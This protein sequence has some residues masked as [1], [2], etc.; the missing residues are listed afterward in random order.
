MGL[1]IS[2]IPEPIPETD[3]VLLQ[4]DANTAHQ[5][6][7]YCPTTRAIDP[8]TYVDAYY[9]VNGTS[10][11]SNP[12]RL[13]HSFPADSDNE[14]PEYFAGSAFNL[15][16]GTLYDTKIEVNEP[17]TTMAVLTGTY[18]TTSLPANAGLPT[19][20]ATPS[21][22]ATI[23]ANPLPAGTVLYLP[24]GTYDLSSGSYGAVVTS[25]GTANNKVYI[26]GES[27]AGTIIQRTTGNYLLNIKGNHIIFDNITFQG[28]G[29]NTGVSSDSKALIVSDTTVFNNH[30]IRFCKFIGFDCG[31]RA[32]TQVNNVLMYENILI[33]NNTHADLTGV[34]IAGWTE[35][36]GWSDSAITIPG[37][38]NEVF[39]NNLS[40]FGDSYKVTDEA[41]TVGMSKASY[42]HH[43][44]IAFS[45]DDGVGEIDDGGRNIYL[46]DNN[47]ANSATLFS[48]DLTHGGPNGAIRNIGINIARH[49]YKLTDRSQGTQIINNTI[50]E[51]TKQTGR[52]FG[53]LLSSSGNPIDLIMRNN[54]LVYTG[55]GGMMQIDAPCPRALGG[56]NGWSRDGSF[57]FGSTGGGTF[58]NLAAAKAGRPDLYLND[59]IVGAAPFNVAVTL[60]ADYK[61]QYTGTRSI[62]LSA[63]SL[64]KNSGIAIG[65]V[66]DGF[67]GVA[68][69]LGAIISGQN[70]GVVGTT[71]AVISGVAEEPSALPTWVPATSTT[72][73]NVN[74]LTKAN[75]GLVNDFIETTAPNYEPFYHATIVNAYSGGVLNK[76]YGEY[77]SFFLTGAGHA[78]GNDN[79]LTAM[80]L[81]EN[82]IS[83]RRVID[84]SPYFDSE[85][86]L[87]PTQIKGLNAFGD[88]NY[89]ISGPGS[90]PDAMGVSRVD[91]ATASAIVDGKPVAIHSYGIPVIIP[92]SEGGSSKGTLYLPMLVAGNRDLAL[93]TGSATSYLTNLT[94][95]T[96]PSNVQAWVR[97]FSHPTYPDGSSQILYNSINPP[98]HCVY[99]PVFSRIMY[100]SADIFQ[101]RWINPS[102]T[103][104]ST[105]WVQGTGTA[106]SRTDMSA[107]AARVL[108]IPERDLFIILYRKLSDSTL[109]IKYMQNAAQ[110]SWNNTNV[111]L[112]SSTL[113]DTDWSAATWCPDIP[114]G[115]RICVFDIK[116]NRNA[117]VEITIPNTLTDTW[118]VEQVGLSQT[119]TNFKTSAQRQADN[120]TVYGRLEYNSKTK[121]IVYYGM[122]GQSL[123]DPDEVF[124]IRPRGV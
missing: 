73:G 61:T 1:Q 111:T 78:A 28:N 30:T 59:K 82:N 50:V 48:A 40:G 103:T 42:F 41:H 49:P 67:T 60:G 11:W 45:S 88:F 25:Q 107:V 10:T 85:T 75:G 34:G 33:G 69:D 110:P 4:Y 36:W 2:F 32:Y 68:P 65:G 70:R 58:P 120:A 101:P 105:W 76:D 43:N 94:D 5:I 21:T 64:A 16:E 95:T 66:T 122:A 38:G 90:G 7:F 14:L 98:I 115:G 113:L 12:I 100:F 18:Q 80:V 112:S 109:A 8:A 71:G 15:L 99:D 117:Y 91:P 53:I 47:A 83:F 86:S 27:Q 119:I 29:I 31:Y 56:Y 104:A 97:K 37:V 35:N 81:G 72:Q 84:P 62:S 52:D 74:L 89:L 23:L 24:N 93:R 79:S 26:V 9:K 92:P 121:S 55:A 46:Y 116:N 77:G 51:T 6:S 54:I 123:A 87:T 57:K 22:L 20:T 13:Y 114:G 17:S 3:A 108:Y 96:T 118:T 39:N 106:L 44:D 63:D 124:V 19:I 102:A